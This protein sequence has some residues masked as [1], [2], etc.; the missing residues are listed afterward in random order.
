MGKP[1]RHSTKELLF[2]AAMS[3][4]GERGYSEASVDAIAA[5]AGVAKGIVYYYFDSKAALAEQLIV[6]GLGFLA[7]RLERAVADDSLSPRQALEALAA[8]EIRQVEKR[9]D[10]AKF[11]LSEMWREDRAW[12]ETLTICIKRI[13]DIFAVQIQRGIDTGDFKPQEDVGF[14][15]QLIFVT[16]LAAA[17]NRTVLHPDISQQELAQRLTSYSLSGLTQ[18]KTPVK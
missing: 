4:I 16:Y 14:L 10:F 18:S 13:T 3:L 7:E 15:A 1:K 8:E 9:H 2:E 6:S 11:L 5:K 12:R 17:L